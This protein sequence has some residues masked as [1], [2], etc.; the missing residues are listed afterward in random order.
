MT[1]PLADRLIREGT[2]RSKALKLIAWWDLFRTSGRLLLI[3]WPFL[4][5]LLAMVIVAHQSM[6]ILAAGRAYVEGESLWSKGQK[7]SVFYLLRYADTHTE[8]YFH[9]YEEAIAVPLG[10]RQARLELE[11]PDPDYEVARAGLLQGRTHPDDIPG[12]MKLYRRFRHV[13]YIDKVIRTW[14]RGDGYIEQLIQVAAELHAKI[15]SGESDPATLA[16]LIQRVRAINEDLTPLEDAFSA[17]LGEATRTTELILMAA[18]IA[19]AATLTPLGIL[20]SRR[21][22]KH[23]EAAEKALKLSEERFKL[24]VSG[25]TD[26]LWD[27]NLDAGE[28]YFSPRFKELIGYADREM[29]NSFAVYVSHL[30]PE[31][32]AATLAAIEKHLRDNTPY[33]VEYRLKTKAGEYRWFRSRARSVRNSKGKAVRMAGSITEIT[34]RKLAEL[35]LFT[36]KERAQ[37]TLQSIGDAVITTDTRGLIEYMNPPGEALIGCKAGDAQGLPLHALCR[38][39]DEKTQKVVPDLVDLVMRDGK[40]VEAPAHSL[41]VRQDG[42][43]IAVDQSAAPIRDRN[44]H[45]AGA[46]LVIRDVNQERQ[47]AAKLT[48]EA[49]HDALTGLINRREFEQ[50]M[51]AALNSAAQYNRHHAV[52]YLD[53]DQFKIVNDTKGHAAGDELMCQVGALLQRRLREGDTLARLGGDEFGVLLENCPHEHALRIADSLRQA[54]FDFQFPWQDRTFRIGVSIGLVNISDAGY[55]L[56][57][58]LKFA[59][60][61]CY[62]AKE[63]GRNR[64]QVYHPQDSDLSERQGEMEWVGE[65]HRALE[66][67]RFVLYAQEIVE[68]GDPGKRGRHFE[69]LVRMRNVRGDL[70]PPMAFI[71]AAERFD[72]MPAIDRWVV[73][74]AL[75]E[76][77]KLRANGRVDLLDSCAINLSGASLQDEEFL[78]VIRDAFARYE[79]PPRMICF[80]ITETAAIDNLDKA[81][82]FIRELK[83]L[84]CHFSLDDFGVGMSSFSYL[85]HLPVDL[86]KID[87]RFVK[88]MLDDQ[89]DRAMV[90]AINNIGHLMGKKTIAEFV[91]TEALL[92]SLREIGVDYAQGF[93]VA[94]PQPFECIGTMGSSG[95][96]VATADLVA[97]G[98]SFATRLDL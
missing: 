58:V 27:W 88:D 9:K 4:A 5:I 22:L 10:D 34:D 66:E 74:T 63:K 28:M 61:A 86:L 1:W 18:T 17:T 84:G 91:E 78:P 35:Q 16:P 87:G 15:A 30:H 51:R 73:N 50:R 8:S 95:T 42:G 77:S 60:A 80:E 89:I 33:D 72:L 71:P 20:F 40:A 26:G 82:Q 85:K 25:S 55:T 90:V 32:K 2:L 47:Y 45:I 67:D 39:V 23:R 59:D 6:Q 38:I 56:S 19:V 7:Q 81:E 36:E 75:R 31:D 54:I 69:L 29:Q 48:Y 62:M 3:I 92:E 37:V 93:G 65:I 49:S 68:V 70:I 97:A 24:A 43:E 94:K 52:L 11:K 64:I 96:S 76:L 13:G 12:V 83:A 57:E 53:L 44:G 41:L 14:A 79:I 46:V 21:M 98:P